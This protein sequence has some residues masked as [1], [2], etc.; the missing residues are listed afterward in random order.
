MTDVRYLPSNDVADLATPADY[1]DAVREGYRER[2]TGAPAKPRTTLHPTHTSGMLT[3]YLA[4]LPEMGY[5]GGYMYSAGFEAG[6]VWFV[7]PLFDA[8]S[9]ELLALID[10]AAMNPYKTGAVGALGIDA[11]AREDATTLGII[12][13][14]SQA[15]G[16]L[17]AATTVRD[18]DQI[19]VY[20]PTEAHR[21]DFATK[22]NEA[23]D[24][25][26]EAVA[27]ADTV[28]EHSDVIITA[29]TA[30]EPVFAGDVLESGT[31]ITAMGQY[32]PDRRE[33]DAT[34]VRSATYVPDL[35]ERAF[36]DAGAFLQALSDGVID[37]DHIHAELGEV[38][39][40]TRPGR[41]S[42]E[43]ITVLD[44]GG[45]AIETVAAAGMLYERAVDAGRGTLVD[46]SPASAA[47]L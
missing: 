39:A 22:M 20:S 24:P 42:D 23:L 36:Q 34:T 47:F 19:T 45:T 7:L 3:G 25:P 37:E 44:S 8:D 21:N 14:G 13:S 5:M 9:G 1:V 31:H 40:G 38:V 43:E 26:V 11:L 15:H 16:Q 18:F 6:D 30:S 32:H 41:T 27:S 4:I 2:G 17:L 28:V 12:G 10:G 33:I 46:L 29:T 35:R